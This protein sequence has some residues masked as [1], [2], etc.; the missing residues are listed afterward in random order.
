MIPAAF[1]YVRADSA[2]A[3]IAQLAEHGDDAKLL[4][5]GMS[6]L[7]LMKL[8]LATPTVVVDVG[9]LRDLSYVRDA[10]DHL[11]IGALTRHR[12]V[13][14]N[15]LLERECG[16][17]RGSR[18]RSATTRCGTAAPLAGRSRT[19][20][21]RPTS[22]PRCACSTRPSSCRGPTA[23]ARSPRPSSSAASSRP[24]SSPTSCSP[25]SA[26]RRP[27][28]TGFAFE[29]F[30]RRAQDFATVGVVAART[31]GATHVG[32]INMGSTPLRATAVEAALAGGASASDAAEHAADGTEPG[33]DLN[34]TAEY[35]EHLARVLGA[36]R[37]RGDL[38][39]RAAAVL[40]AGRGLR[41]GGDTP[42]PLLAFRGHAARR[43]RGRRR[44]RERARARRGGRVRPAS[45]RGGRRRRAC[46]PE[47]CPRSGD[48]VEPARGAGARSPATPRSTGSS[49]VSATSPSS[50]RRRT[51]ASRPRST[52]APV[53]PSPRTPARAGTPCSSAASTGR[54][55]SRSPATRARG[56]CSGGTGR[57]R[58]RATEP[59]SRPTS[60]RP[61]TSR[62]SKRA[63][64]ATLRRTD[65]DR[66]QLPGEHTHRRDVEGAARHRGHRAVPARRPAPRSRGRRVPRHR[67]GE[68]RA[69]HRA[70]QGHRD[71]HRGQTKPTT[72]S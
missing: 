24:R 70:V 40:A 32:L 10:G 18:R 37:A 11:A 34:A 53:S 2:D 50:A 26:S 16:V 51:G 57:A 22:R 13:E 30:N 49:W 25:R 45:R 36:P 5:G 39:H 8:R 42:K 60:T 3:A 12:D 31:N 71:A 19:A 63:H 66:R 47:R 67:E 46:R 33:S 38:T 56:S 64:R 72:R 59:A 4:A 9:R 35:R 1:D 68:G 54:R 7:P 29:K 28:A 23:P 43:A 21:R 17:L 14:T 15:D 61:Q 65:G 27:G 48:R 6:L 41:F 69:D 62:R 20:I 52:T 44:S 55:R 58:Y